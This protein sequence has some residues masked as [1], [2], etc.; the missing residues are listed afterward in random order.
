VLA[1]EVGLPESLR[2]TDTNN[3]NPRLG[4]AWRPFGDNRTVI[5]GGIGSYTVPLYGSINYSLVATVTSDVPIFFNQRTPGGFAITFPNVFPAALRAV[6]G[7]GSQDF[8]RA[9]QFDLRD[10]RMTQWSVTLERD[11]G[12]N[13]GLRVSY[14]GNT[15]DDI[16]V[17][18]DLN[19]IQP[20]TQGYAAL[21]G[22][23]PFRD[24]NVVTS[25][26]N[27]AHARYD[28]LQI[29]V[30]RRLTKGLT[31]DGSY[32]LARHLS[33]AGGAVPGD[34]PAENGPS[35]LNTF[36]GP[37]DD[38]GPM[39]FTRRHRF[40]A[41]FLYE[42]PFGRGRTFGSGMGRGLDVLVGGW[43]VAGVLL[44]QSGSFLTPMFTGGD[45]SGT[46][47]NVRG[48]TS[49][50]RPDQTGD[51]NLD[52]PTVERFFNRDVFEIPA[53]NIGRF[54]NAEVG[55]LIGPKTSVLSLSVGKSFAI[56]GSSRMR[57]EAAFSN[58]FDTENFG[59][60]N[61]N[62]RSGQFGLITNTQ[63]VDQ[64]GPRTV[65]FSLRYSF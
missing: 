8:R 35:L 17:S 50:T 44:A 4:L 57:F 16:I 5:R 34:F 31:L 55:S 56:A 37:D 45:P 1:E 43:D 11:L 53:N 38:Y 18:P 6:P 19:Q 13:T 64:A 32:T 58:L 22:T 23:R 10:P 20:N 48:F 30:T 60:P 63:S 52:N 7:A 41:T 42:L 47:A 12:A 36:R 28:G 26:D 62:V 25:R 27:G 2:E 21:A 54:G 9:N 40:V 3:L 49:T 29:E 15:T 61:R 51:G 46:G 14:I 24:W 33:D 39:P 59:L 65:Q